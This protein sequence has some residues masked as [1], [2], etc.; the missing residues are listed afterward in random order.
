MKI[1]GSPPCCEVPESGH[2]FDHPD[3]QF[4]PLV[5]GRLTSTPGFICEVR[6]DRVIRSGTTPKRC[7]YVSSFINKTYYQAEKNLHA[8]YRNCQLAA[9]MHD[10]KYNLYVAYFLLSKG[11]I[12]Q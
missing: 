1:Q 9:Q 12:V 3:P 6:S 7:D 10:K 8:S 11:Y 2:A 4:F 5:C